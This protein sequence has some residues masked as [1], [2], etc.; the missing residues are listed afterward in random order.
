M[1]DVM[2]FAVGGGCVFGCVWGGC[3]ICDVWGV[4][5]WMCGVC[6]AYVM[7]VAACGGVRLD[8]WGVS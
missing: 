5:V 8:E 7:G 4:C 3:Y 2:S 1:C 6:V